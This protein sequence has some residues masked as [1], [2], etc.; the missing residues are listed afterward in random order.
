MRDY[1]LILR[2]HLQ[3]SS[4]P[5]NVLYNEK[6]QFK[7]F[8]LRLAVM[9]VFSLLQSGTVAQSFLGFHKLGVLNR[10]RTPLL[11]LLCHQDQKETSICLP[12]LPP[13]LEASVQ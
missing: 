8:F 11:L 12:P 13:I 4:C 10:P 1:R 3:L 9:A 6:M 7:K 2:P 5:S